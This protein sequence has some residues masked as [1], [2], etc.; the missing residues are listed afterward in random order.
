MDLDLALVLYIDHHCPI[1]T[2]LVTNQ[3]KLCLKCSSTASVQRWTTIQFK[4][5]TSISTFFVRKSGELLTRKKY[6]TYQNSK[7]NYG[8]L[9]YINCTHNGNNKVQWN[10]KIWLY[11]YQPVLLLDLNRHLSYISL[12]IL[13]VWLDLRLRYVTS[14]SESDPPTQCWDGDRTGGQNISTKLR[15]EQTD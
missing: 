6:Y 12:I 8:N 11:T 15:I 10:W 14:D 3:C 1:I 7:F 9:Y 5:T 4:I 13:W 2:I